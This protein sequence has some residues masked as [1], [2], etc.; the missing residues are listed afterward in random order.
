MTE[1]EFMKQSLLTFFVP[2]LKKLGFDGMFPHYHRITKDKVDFLSIIF[3]KWGGAF[4]IEISFAYFNM[5]PSNLLVGAEKIPP[6]KLTVYKTIKRER[7]PY[8]GQWIHFCDCVQVKTPNGSNEY[9]LTQKQK[10][11]FLKNIPEKNITIKN[12]SEG[13]YCRS[14]LL[15]VKYLKRAEI[16]WM[17]HQPNIP[18]QKQH[19]DKPK[20]DLINEGSRNSRNFFKKC[21]KSK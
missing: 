18:N 9:Y 3:D 21:R 20:E 8:A 11:V 1:K 12:S 17:E 5:K 2:E 15:A 4:S 13:I 10:E 7:F 14:A 16:W 6:E 19:F